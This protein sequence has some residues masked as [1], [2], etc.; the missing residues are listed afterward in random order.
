[1][2]SSKTAVHHRHAN[3]PAE[4]LGETVVVPAGPRLHYLRHVRTFGGR[5]R[6]LRHASRCGGSSRA[7]SCWISRLVGPPWWR[8]TGRRCLCCVHVSPP[9]RSTQRRRRG[10]RKSRAKSRRCTGSVSGRAPR[11][12]PLARTGRG[13]R[14]AERCRVRGPDH[15]VSAHAA[16]RRLREDGRNV[17]SAD[18]QGGLWLKLTADEHAEVS[19]RLSEVGVGEAVLSPQPR[20]PLWRRLF[21]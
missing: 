11:T 2:P 10:P 18:D 20:A 19:R 3:E 13:P 7:P 16:G 6:Q 4:G 5:R 8:P 12:R 1:M 9:W 17:Y 21:G 14:P 15:P